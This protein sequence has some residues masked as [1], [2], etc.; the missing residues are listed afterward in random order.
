MTNKPGRL[1]RSIADI[2]TFYAILLVIVALGI[3]GFAVYTINYNVQQSEILR[4]LEKTAQQVSLGISSYLKVATNTLEVFATAKSLAR[5][6]PVAQSDALNQLLNQQRR[7][8]NELAWLDA[9]GYEQARVSP[10]RV[11]QV[12]ELV[13]R[14]AMPEYVVPASGMIYVGPIE[15][16]TQSNVPVAIIGVPVHSSTGDLE[17]V[18]VAEV[19]LKEMWDVVSTVEF[20]QTGYVYVVDEQGQLR[21]FS[22]LAEAYRRF[23]QD[24]SYIPEVARFIQGVLWDVD[25][26]HRYVGVTGQEVIGSYALIEEPVGWGVIIELPTA[27]AFVGLNRATQSLVA[28]LIVV[29]VVIAISSPVLLRT[30][31][32]DL[33]QLREG[34]EQFARGELTHRIVLGR[35]DELG[36][37][38]QVLNSMGEQ[39]ASIIASLEQRVQ[40][41][42]SDLERRSAYLRASAEV[43]RAVTSIL[44][45]DELIQTIVGFVREQF[46]LYYVG[47]F[48][49]DESEEWVVLRAGTGSAGRAMLSGGHKLAVG[50]DSMIGQ[51]VARNEVRLALDVGAEAVRFENPYLPETRSEMALPLQSRGRVLGALTIQS[52]EEAAFAEELITVLRT[53]ADQLAVALNNAQLFAEAQVALESERRAYGE[54]SRDA[55]LQM[56]QTRSDWGYV[57]DQAGITVARGKW[58]SEM[59][60][61]LDTGH[62]IVPD[63]DS[64]PV[65]G[66]PL[67][68]R[69]QTVGVVS[70]QKPDGARDWTQEENAL[71]ETLAE[72]LGVAL[73]SAR[74]YEDTQR[75]AVRE[76]LVSEISAHLRQS[77]DVTTVLRTVAAELGRLPGV[78]E[79]TVHVALPES[80]VVAPAAVDT[81]EERA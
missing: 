15:I 78:A 13:D 51:C 56:L 70:F 33:D 32:R 25:Q 74:L 35:Q 29:A 9:Q 64:A 75:R 18:L 54:V 24:V 37:L 65:L 17:G 72:Q 46:D 77:L 69:D 6:E 41:R 45:I 26:Q 2:F 7:L 55:W 3:A 63:T 34:A 30:I 68:V 11:V 62:A 22:V 59:Q 5:L 60:Q 14:A 67:R 36:V 48:L 1:R 50:G 49:V 52:T 73:E 12:S 28:V 57:C 80:S 61:V 20:G 66:V 53:L 10:F 71:I 76:R 43:G 4:G 21:A 42:T 31:R 39:L 8:F 47:L 38:A 44:D 19:I 58:S 40:E 81:E 79:A 16:S 27:E 23:G